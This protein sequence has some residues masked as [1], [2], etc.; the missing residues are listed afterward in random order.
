MSRN[1]GP[2]NA[3]DRV[4]SFDCKLCSSLIEAP[5][6]PGLFDLAKNNKNYDE[7]MKGRVSYSTELG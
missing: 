5:V 2:Q 1:S 7:L 6:V 4:I 3:A